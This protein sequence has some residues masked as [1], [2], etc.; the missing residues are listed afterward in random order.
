MI[1][2][3]SSKQSVQ[4]YLACYF[5]RL[6]LGISSCF[7]KAVFGCLQARFAALELLLLVSLYGS[8]MDLQ[9]T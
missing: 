2:K 4:G 8:L 3:F 9:K 1:S 5:G 7:L 6:F